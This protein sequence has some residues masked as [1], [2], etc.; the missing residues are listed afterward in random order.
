VR[1]HITCPSECDGTDN[2]T[3]MASSLTWLLSIDMLWY[4]SDCVQPDEMD[5]APR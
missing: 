1:T 3:S 5:A 4:I 2:D